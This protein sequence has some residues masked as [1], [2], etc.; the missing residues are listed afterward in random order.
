MQAGLWSGCGLL[1]QRDDALNRPLDDGGI[2]TV[3]PYLGD[4]FTG[5]CP[6]KTPSASCHTLCSLAAMSWT[7]NFPLHAFVNPKYWIDKYWRRKTISAVDRLER[8][9]FKNPLWTVCLSHPKSV[10]TGSL[11]D[12]VLSS[13][14]FLNPPRAPIQVCH[15]TNLLQQN[16]QR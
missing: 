2:R 11:A 7:A 12:S 9:Y 3:G 1:Y 8:L 15:L 4:Q 13:L 14:F 5:T 10:L 16:T 6:G